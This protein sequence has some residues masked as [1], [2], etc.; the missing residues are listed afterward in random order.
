MTVCTQV[1]VVRSESL[2][3]LNLRVA[4][5]ATLLHLTVYTCSLV[6]KWQSPQEKSW[7]VSLVRPIPP[8]APLS[9]IRVI[10]HDL[11]FCPIHS[12]YETTA[13]IVCTSSP[14]PSACLQV[15]KDICASPRTHQ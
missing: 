1:G 12:Y 2:N 3:F 5:T 10:D 13:L 4:T 9:A 8:L 7:K 11:T 6:P 15:F 14:R